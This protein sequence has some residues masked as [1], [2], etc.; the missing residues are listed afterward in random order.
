MFVYIGIALVGFFYIWKKGVLDWGLTVTQQP[1]ATR[2]QQ[3][4]S[5]PD[6]AE[7]ALVGASGR[8]GL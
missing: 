5:T 7:A 4:P 8:G 2:S 1:R 6:S 3:P